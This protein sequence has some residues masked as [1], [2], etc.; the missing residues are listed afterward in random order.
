MSRGIPMTYN[1]AAT[2]FVR[3]RR[4]IEQAREEARLAVEILTGADPATGATPTSAVE[5]TALLGQLE[6]L[7]RSLEAT[8][9]DLRGL[10][11]AG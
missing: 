8:E 10:E 2:A 7:L 9:R 3:S 6:R 1:R 4:L 5:R 11:E